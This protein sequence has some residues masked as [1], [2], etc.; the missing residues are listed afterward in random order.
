MKLK[1]LEKQIT[2]LKKQ[3]VIFKK[4]YYN[5][6]IVK[7]NKKINYYGKTNSETKIFNVANYI[8]KKKRRT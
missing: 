3:F 5:I 6:S 4:K 7:K 1:K 8:I 2:K